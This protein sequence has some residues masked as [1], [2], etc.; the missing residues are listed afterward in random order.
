[1]DSCDV[2]VGSCAGHGGNGGGWHERL[3]G[4]GT[5]DHLDEVGGQVREVRDGLVLDLPIFAVGAAQQ[6]C[7][8]VPL[9]PVLTD[10]VATVGRYMDRATSSRHNRTLL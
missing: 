4:Q 1:V 2:P 9:H 7:L 6:V 8:V 10:V 5:A 3:A